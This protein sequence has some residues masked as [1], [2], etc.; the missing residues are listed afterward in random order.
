MRRGSNRPLPAPPDSSLRGDWRTVSALLPYLTA[1]KGRVLFALACLIGAKLANVG[2]PLVLK[3]I[4]D[5]LTAPQM[6]VLPLGLIAAYG[7]MRL[8]TTVFT[9]LREYLFAKV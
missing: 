8:S 7:A 3:Q 9:E 4:V 6:L 1:Y 2:V 5:S